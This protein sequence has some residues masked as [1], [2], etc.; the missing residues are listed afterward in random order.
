MTLR[1]P[2]PGMAQQLGDRRVAVPF[3][4]SDA[5]EDALQVVRARVVQPRCVAER[6]DRAFQVGAAGIAGSVPAAPNID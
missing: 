5:A 1:H 2:K 6:G 4:C 3:F